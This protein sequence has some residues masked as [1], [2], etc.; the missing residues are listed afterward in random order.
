MV[1]KLE[2]AIIIIIGIIPVA[3]V[4]NADV[5]FADVANLLFLD[6]VD[7]LSFALNFENDRVNVFEL[8]ARR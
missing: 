1:T 7:G 2:N 3:E 6:G 4:R 5:L 8:V